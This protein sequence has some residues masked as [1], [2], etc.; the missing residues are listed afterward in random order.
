MEILASLEGSAIRRLKQSWAVLPK[1]YQADL[2][3]LGNLMKPTKNFKEYRNAL[4]TA[5]YPCIPYLGL[6]LTDL[7]FID[8]GNDDLVHNGLINVEKLDLTAKVC[9]TIS[10]CVSADYSNLKPRNALQK[11]LHSVEVWEDNEIY[12]LSK[13][14]EP[15]GQQGSV[16]A[17]KKKN[18]LGNVAKDMLKK[19]NVQASRDL[20]TEDWDILLKSANMVTYS[21]DKTIIQ[22]GEVNKIMYKIKS[23]KVRVEK[24]VEVDNKTTAVVLGAMEAGRVFGE[25]SIIS[26]DNRPTINCVADEETELYAFDYKTLHKAFD[27]H[28]AIARR[29]YMWSAKKLSEMLIKLVPKKDTIEKSASSLDVKK[30]DD[31]NNVSNVNEEES[32]G[33]RYCTLFNLPSGKLFI[34]SLKYLFIFF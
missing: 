22:Q 31:E 11:M 8:D 6:H 23:G 32:E 20:S 28:P 18:G 16:V 24:R 1:N 12:R 27:G 26:D 5:N 21:K 34:T 2:D 29:F 19:S 30:I 17:S 13:F 3:R 25:M 4:E 15:Q 33:A 7:T 14:R 9:N 10:S